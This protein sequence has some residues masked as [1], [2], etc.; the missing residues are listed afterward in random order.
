MSETASPRE[1]DST[2]GLSVSEHTRFLHDAF[3]DLAE[4]NIQRLGV[5]L[6]DI[7]L[8]RAI[9]VIAL[10][11]TMKR[12]QNGDREE[13]PEGHVDNAEDSTDVYEFINR[14][15]KRRRFA[16]EKSGC[17]VEKMGKSVIVLENLVEVMGK[18]VDNILEEAKDLNATLKELEGDHQD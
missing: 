14:G 12:I 7:A 18:R 9:A 8:A 4:D 5:E 1:R 13:E 17:D 2:P 15:R 3:T 16:G 6:G 11:V 10:Q